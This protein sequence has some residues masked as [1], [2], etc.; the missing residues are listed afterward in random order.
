MGIAG[1]LVSKQGGVM[2]EVTYLQMAWVCWAAYG[3]GYFGRM[4]YVWLER[5]GP[6]FG[7]PPDA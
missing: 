7:A 1:T 4:L 2:F 3:A 5:R 6:E